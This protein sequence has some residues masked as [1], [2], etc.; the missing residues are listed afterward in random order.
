MTI[1][2]QQDSMP[3]VHQYSWQFMVKNNIWEIS[4]NFTMTS[5]RSDVIDLPLTPQQGWNQSAAF[6][7]SITSDQLK[8]DRKCR[9]SSAQQLWNAYMCLES[10]NSQHNMMMPPSCQLER[11]VMET[12]K[13]HTQDSSFWLFFPRVTSWFAGGAIFTGCYIRCGSCSQYKALF[14]LLFVAFYPRLWWELNAAHLPY[15]HLV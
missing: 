3:R 4:S 1:T 15:L 8:Q 6:N 2:S 7:L 11:V 10:T 13:W 5:L 9:R 12:A 14:S